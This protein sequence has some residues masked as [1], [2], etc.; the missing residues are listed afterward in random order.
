M[1]SISLKHTLFV[2]LRPK[3]FLVHFCCSQVYGVIVDSLTNL[4][5]TC[6]YLLDFNPLAFS[7]HWSA[8]Y[9][10]FSDIYHYCRKIKKNPGKNRKKES[11]VKTPNEISH[12]HITWPWVQGH[13]Y[14]YWSEKVLHRLVL[15]ISH[16]Q[17][18]CPRHLPSGVSSIPHKPFMSEG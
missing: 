8:I 11:W 1:F 9:V 6:C 18:W 5:S 12:S 3:A 15:E 4:G 14:L 16:S 7:A 13:Q 17:L 2:S 10:H